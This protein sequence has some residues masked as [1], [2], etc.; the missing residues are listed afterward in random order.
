MLAGKVVERSMDIGGAAQT[1]VTGHFALKGFEAAKG[2]LFKALQLGLHR[3]FGALPSDG[4]QFVGLAILP[5]DGV[6][7]VFLMATNAVRL[8]QFGGA[9]EDGH[10]GRLAGVVDRHPAHATNAVG[11]PIT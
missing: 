8:G 9:A 2:F 5:E 7:I 6:G 4:G 10:A 11:Q 1:V 3:S